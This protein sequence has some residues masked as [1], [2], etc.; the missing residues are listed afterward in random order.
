[1][2]FLP[3]QVAVYNRRRD[4]NEYEN[5][6]EID[7]RSYSHAQNRMGSKYEFEDQSY[8]SELPTKKRKNETTVYE[9]TPK[10]TLVFSKEE[11]NDDEVVD[12]NFNTFAYFS[13]P[14]F[15]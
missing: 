3:S 1:M 14:L 7:P 5:Q 9:F 12:R 15:R 13:C 11:E 10:R 8:Y 6:A 4:Y 2:E